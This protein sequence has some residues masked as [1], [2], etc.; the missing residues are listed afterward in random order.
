MAKQYNDQD[1]PWK[2]IL[3]N[4]FPEFIKFFFGNV[5][6][7]IDWDKGYTFLD[8]E[9]QKIIRASEQGRKIVDKLIK[10]WRKDGQNSK[11]SK[12]IWVLIHIEIQAQKEADFEERIYTYNYRLY[13]RYHHKVA[14]F[15]ILTDENRR[16]RPSQFG[17]Q[18]WGSEVKLKFVAVKLID[19]KKQW[20]ALELSD[21]PFATVVMAHLQT[22]ATK[23]NSHQRLTWK[24][25]LVKRL[26]QKGYSKNDIQEL[27]RFIE[28]IMI[29]PEELEQ[30]FQMELD[31]FE[32]ENNMPY[33][34]NI[35]R[36]G[37]KKGLEQ[38]REEGIREGIVDILEVRFGQISESL[39]KKLDQIKEFTQLKDLHKKAITITTLLEFEEM[40]N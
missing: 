25:N 13:D 14:S 22:Q 2:E 8:K 17:Y 39:R 11:D 15:A 30:S 3:E 4:Y 9:L 10:V 20:A 27:F 6:Q 23:K 12:E 28:W 31:R 1:S 24:L 29:L 21:N 33:V 5:Y 18:L 34:T 7:E 19:Y 35:E 40:L 38:G 26:Y 36:K 16:W 37:I 32:E